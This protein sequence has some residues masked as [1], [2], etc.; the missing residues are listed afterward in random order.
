[1]QLDADDASVRCADGMYG[2]VSRQCSAIAPGDYIRS[3]MIRN[4]VLEVVKITRFGR[5]AKDRP[6]H[7]RFA[8]SP[9][10]D[11]RLIQSIK[12]SQIKATQI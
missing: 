9:T 12:S 6:A 10:M 7:L 2:V 8:E 11:F 4:R 3:L 1:M 5:S